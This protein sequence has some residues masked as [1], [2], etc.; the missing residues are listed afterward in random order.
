MF[1]S[2]P[3]FVHIGDER[4]GVIGVR[5]RASHPASATTILTLPIFVQKNVRGHNVTTVR[6]VSK[7]AFVRRVNQGPGWNV[8]KQMERVHDM[9]YDVVQWTLCKGVAVVIVS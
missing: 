8:K 5:E 6:G 7:R 1:Y 9:E 3:V 4:R 2:H